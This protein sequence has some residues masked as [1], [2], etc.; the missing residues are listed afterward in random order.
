MSEKI[1]VRLRRPTID[2]DERPWHT[3][4][5]WWPTLESILR[6][7]NT[8]AVALFRELPSDVLGL[9]EDPVFG[10]Y[11]DIVSGTGR[12]RIFGQRS[13][14]PD[15]QV[16]SRYMIAVLPPG[17]SLPTPEEVSVLLAASKAPQGIES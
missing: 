13:A 2:V 6:H 4:Q 11:I 1:T 7:G 5:A 10:C 9:K 16:R 14:V 3:T 15:E 17:I 8:A 12:A